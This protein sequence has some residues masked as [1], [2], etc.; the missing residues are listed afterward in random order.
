MNEVQV[1]IVGAGIG[2]LTAAV[3]CAGRGLDVLVLERAAAPGGKIATAM[4][5]GKSVDA[6]P[7]VLT[8]LEVFDELFESA[9][10]RREDFVTAVPLDELACHYWPGGSSLSLHSD[11]EKSAAAIR[12]FAGA[13]EERGFRAFCEASGA[14]YQALRDTFMFHDR[15][16]N[17]LSL[18]LRGG[19]SGLSG[20]TRL[21]PYRP[22][23]A[24]V[25]EHF[26]DPRLRQLFGRYSTYSGSS[27]FVA[28]ATLALIAEVERRGVWRIEGGMAAVASGLEQAARALGVRF[29]YDCEVAR[30]ETRAGHVQ[31]VTLAGGERIEAEQV[32]LNADAAALADGLFGDAPARRT[33]AF[34]AGDRS[35][36]AFTVA[37]DA[38]LKGVAPAHHTVFFSADSRA[39]FDAL[40]AGRMPKEPTVYACFQDRVEGAPPPTGP[41]R[42]L[43]VLNAPADGDRHAY[44]AEEI[45]RCTNN[46]LLT[47]ARAGLS[48]EMAAPP[49]ISTPSDFAR[50][51]PAT[52]GALYGRASHGWMASFRRPGARTAIPGLYLAGGSVHPGAGVPMAALSGRA[53][54][55]ALVLDR[56]STSTFRKAATPGG[57]STPSARTGATA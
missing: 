26:R 54:V 25:G 4:V 1:I 27:P 53:A 46:A 29:A 45:D 5:G 22:L 43:L 31:G 2:G 7:T 30:V 47:M 35:F 23:A 42:A 9:G 37:L 18:M 20:F 49:S 14:I 33:R 50:R 57:I 40:A 39:E 52:G 17:P 21:D 32:V 36:S 55:R 10:L 44:S 15:P 38:R 3:D 13:Q 56:A 12:A 41:E 6:G 48:I 19:V 24:M 28:P 16:A 8:L 51:F 11:I 34:D